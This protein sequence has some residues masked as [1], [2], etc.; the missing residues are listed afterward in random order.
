M[1]E[2]DKHRF[3]GKMTAFALIQFK[4]KLTKIKKTGLFD[5][6]CDI[7]AAAYNAELI[8]FNDAVGGKDFAYA[9]IGLVEGIFFTKSVFAFTFED[10]AL[11]AFC[12]CIDMVENREKSAV[13]NIGMSDEYVFFKLIE[14]RN[15][16]IDNGEHFVFIAGITGVNEEVFAIAGDDS[17]IAAAGRFDEGDRGVVGDFVGCNAG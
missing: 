7:S 6:L 15:D 4:M 11:S 5:R 10:Q 14:I 9:D 17:S 12:T 3:S 13:V 1:L 16:A 8:W 2:V